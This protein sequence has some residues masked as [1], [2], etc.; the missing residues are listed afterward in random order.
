MWRSWT[1]SPSNVLNST[2]WWVSLSEWICD[3]NMLI[4]KYPLAAVV[5]SY[6]AYPHESMRILAKLW[7]KSRWHLIQTLKQWMTVL[8]PQ[9][10]VVWIYQNEKQKMSKV[11]KSKNMAIPAFA[12]VLI[13]I[14]IDDVKKFVKDKNIYTSALR[15]YKCNFEMWVDMS[16]L[17]SWNDNEKHCVQA[18]KT[19]SRGVGL[20]CMSKW[21][22]YDE[23]SIRTIYQF[24]DRFMFDV[25][26]CD[27]EEDGWCRR[28]FTLTNRNIE[29][30]PDDLSD[31]DYFVKEFVLEY[32]YSMDLANFKTIAEEDTHIRKFLD[33]RESLKFDLE[34]YTECWVF[35]IEYATSH[36]KRLKEILLCTKDYGI[37][38]AISPKLFEFW[39]NRGIGLMV[40]H[41]SNL[42]MMTNS[43]RSIKFKIGHLIRADR[44]KLSVLIFKCDVEVSCAGLT[45]WKNLF[46]SSD[47]MF[48][49]CE[50]TEVK[51]VKGWTFEG[52]TIPQYRKPI[53][54]IKD[55][56][57]ID[58]NLF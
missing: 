43:K 7:K 11:N 15:D 24:D 51:E 36:M 48:S 56:D 1:E 25:G 31:R 55:E 39:S 27:T 50:V 2:F 44:N 26:E 8:K 35:F 20:N 41:S 13:R 17:H 23:Y 54:A 37:R 22:K 29:D 5:L 34:N 16:R 52:V 47:Y 14:I 21:V 33:S 9:M 45:H 49:F 10:K 30:F 6:F 38:L 28:K 18:I 40:E 46:L 12:F 58:T 53:L 57:I 4:W 32:R 19:I 42:L 3:Y